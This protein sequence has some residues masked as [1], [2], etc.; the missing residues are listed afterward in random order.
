MPSTLPTPSSRLSRCRLPPALGALLGSW[1][2]LAVPA[3]EPAPPP[4]LDGGDEQAVD[5]RTADGMRGA[6]SPPPIRSCADV[7]GPRRDEP[8]YVAPDRAAELAKKHEGSPCEGPFTDA[9]NSTWACP[10]GASVLVCGRSSGLPGVGCSCVDG[11][12]KCGS[13]YAVA[14]RQ[15]MVSCPDGGGPDR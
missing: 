8:E 11:R 7:W 4:G 6:E 2:S 14:A 12:L 10:H 9:L 13:G 1:L 5:Q 15:E 3:C